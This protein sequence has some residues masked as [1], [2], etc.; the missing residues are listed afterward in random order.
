M[1][2]DLTAAAVNESTATATGAQAIAGIVNLK[3]NGSR[4]DL[5]ILDTGLII[6]P[7]L[8][9]LKQKKVKP[10]MFHMLTEVPAR[11]LASAPGHR[12][13]AYEEIATGALVRR[14]PLTFQFVLHSGERLKIRW[15]SESEEMGNGWEA[16][17]NAVATMTP[18]S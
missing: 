2:V 13:I 14:M 9:R 16:L 18:T 3:I 7:G 17:G 1:G 8:P 12:F 15:G 11:E 6:A 5:V 4:Q 10:R